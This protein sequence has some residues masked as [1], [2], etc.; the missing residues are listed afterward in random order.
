MA[1]LSEAFA[2]AARCCRAFLRVRARAQAYPCFCTDEELEQMKAD[3]AE[4][5]LPP[6]Y[7]LMADPSVSVGH[8]AAERV[9]S[10][11]EAVSPPHP[12]TP[13]PRLHLGQ[14]PHTTLLVTARHLRA[15][16]FLLHT[17]LSFHALL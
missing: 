14:T 16:L 4:K 10:A 2:T 9:E 15:L 5:G 7:R 1:L 6:I 13:S 11:R 17:T 8:S 12:P 3:A